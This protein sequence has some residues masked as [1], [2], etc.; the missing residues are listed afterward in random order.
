MARV[1]RISKSPNVDDILESVESPEKS[2]R[3]HGPGRYDVDEHSLGPFPGTKV[4][5][6]AWGKMTDH[7]DSQV[8]LNPIAV[9]SLFSQRLQS[10]AAWIFWWTGEVLR[11]TA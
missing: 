6:R 7:Q 1:Y 9:P 11:W 2:A 3:H 5:A 8:V 4:S 10:K